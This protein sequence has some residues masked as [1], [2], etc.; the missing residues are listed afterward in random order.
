MGST[1]LMTKIGLGLLVV[2]AF[3]LATPARADAAFVA[4]I[5]DDAACD[6]SALD[7][8]A[9]DGDA[10]GVIVLANALLG[11][12]TV[13]TSRSKGN[14]GSATDPSMDISYSMGGAGTVWIYATDTDF[15]G[16]GMFFGTNDGNFAGTATITTY[17]CGGNSN[18]ELDLTNCSTS[19][20]GTSSPFSLQLTHDAATTSPYSLTLG[21][22]IVKTDSGA[23]SGDYLV[24]T[25]EPV[26]MALLGLGLAGFG[27]ATRR[28]NK[29][30]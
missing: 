6:G 14:I 2:G 3:V 26:S 28:R 13:T 5:C 4:W 18:N 24:T 15:L 25:P 9:T 23:L 19:S 27:V 16:S 21:I 20:D 11:N 10:D 8:M 30:R 1:K 7:M 22:K 12:V 29:N 17:L